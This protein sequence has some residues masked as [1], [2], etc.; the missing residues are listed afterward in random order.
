MSDESLPEGIYQLLTHP[1]KRLELV[2]EPCTEE[3][4]SFIRRMQK[5]MYHIMKEYNGVGLAAI[6]A[7]V[8]KRFCILLTGGVSPLNAKVEDILCLINPKVVESEGCVEE[9][10]G[11]LSLP[12]F[13]EVTA[14]PKQITVEFKDLEWKDVTAVFTDVEARCILHEI[15]HMQGVTQ[16]SKLSLM[17]RQMYEKKLLKGRK[18]GKITR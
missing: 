2:S 3:D 9:A 17:K 18:Y 11:C 16:L 4:L 6:Q 15:E 14:R 1:D 7:G 13:S 10:E 12:E 5:P 8:A